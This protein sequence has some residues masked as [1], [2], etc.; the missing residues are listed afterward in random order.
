MLWYTGEFSSQLSHT[1]QGYSHLFRLGVNKVQRMGQNVIL[2][3][4]FVNKVLLE[5]N[6]THSC[7]YSLW[8]LSR[9]SGRTKNIYYLGLCRKTLL[10]FYQPQNIS[11]VMIG[12]CVVLLKIKDFLW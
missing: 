2:L 8:R 1:G 10:N 6:S 7:M 3:P 12:K 4:V 9:Y 5:R 11:E